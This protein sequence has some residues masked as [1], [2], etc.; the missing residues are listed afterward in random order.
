ML[1][2]LKAAEG[3]KRKN[4]LIVIKNGP[5]SR[6]FV[7]SLSDVLLC[8]KDYNVSTYMCDSDYFDDD[9]REFCEQ[10]GTDLL[11]FV[12]STVGFCT[13]AIAAL[14]ADS[15]ELEN[16]HSCVAVPL[17]VRSYQKVLSTMKERGPGALDERAM[18]SLTSVFDIRVKD[19]KIHLDK[20]LRF[21]C[22]GFQ[23]HDIVCVPLA[24][25]SANGAQT[26][27][28]KYIHTRFTTSNNGTC[29]CLLDHL[30]H[31]DTKS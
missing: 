27:I 6:E 26:D 25:V 1:G 14:V 23:P 28:K 9:M 19:K 8:A 30:K 12:Q 20:K 18:E 2:A 10:N 13:Q 3:E 7:A 17:Q 15:S 11:V 22:D 16:A 21:E 29:G 5:I 24:T 31:M 4:V